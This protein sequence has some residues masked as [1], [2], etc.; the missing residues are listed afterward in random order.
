MRWR[1]SLRFQ[2]KTVPPKNFSHSW[3]T[4]QNF[5]S[6]NIETK[7][8]LRTNHIPSDSFCFIVVF[9]ENHVIVFPI[10]SI[11]CKKKPRNKKLS[12]KQNLAESYRMLTQIENLDRTRS[13]ISAI[14]MLKRPWIPHQRLFL[15][16]ET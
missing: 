6:K 16:T 1:K 5:M 15:L 9:A 10:P 4:S 14:T 11:L 2:K 7:N 13:E 8:S 12:S 3:E